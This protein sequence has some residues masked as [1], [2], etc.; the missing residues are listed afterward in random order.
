MLCM[1]ILSSRIDKDVVDKDNDKLI[2]VG[3]E[4][5]THHIHEDCRCIGDSKRHH[6]KLMMVAMRHKYSLGYILLSDLQLMI[7]CPEVYLRKA[8]CSL[9]HIKQLVNP[10][11]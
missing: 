2:Q 3:P 9:K 10:G 8:S 5:P 7:T 4:D 6:C 11:H 1:L